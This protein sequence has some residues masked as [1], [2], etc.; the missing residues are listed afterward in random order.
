ML[1]NAS[2]KFVVALLQRGAVLVERNER[3]S[4]IEKARVHLIVV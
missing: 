4:D 3:K 1:R 2:D